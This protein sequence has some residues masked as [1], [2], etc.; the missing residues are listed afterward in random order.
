MHMLLKIAQTNGRVAILVTNQMQ[1]APDQV[2]G[3]NPIPIGGYIMSYASTYRI[4]LRRVYPEKFCAK[5]GISPGHPQLDTDFAIDKRG[6]GDYID[7]QKGYL[8]V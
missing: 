2:F 8:S 4:P 6:V 5:L 7:N 3:S 1:S